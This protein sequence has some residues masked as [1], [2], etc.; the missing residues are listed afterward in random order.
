MSVSRDEPPKI[1]ITVEIRQVKIQDDIVQGA[2]A[3]TILRDEKKSVSVAAAHPDS[4]REA[5]GLQLREAHGGLH[6]QVRDRAG[7]RPARRALPR[8]P[9]PLQVQ[10]EVQDRR[11]VRGQALRQG[12]ADPGEKHQGAGRRALQRERQAHPGRDEE[13]RRRGD[14]APELAEE[15]V[16]D[17]AQRHQQRAAGPRE[18]RLLPPRRRR[19]E[20]SRAPQEE[21]KRRRLRRAGQARLHQPDTTG[22]Q[23]RQRARLDPHPQKTAGPRSVLSAHPAARSRT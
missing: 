8:D 14:H 10:Q 7:G 23:V 2:E 1:E 3:M 6:L 16:Q 5:S 15:R 19:E 11:L 9:L 17:Q 22:R 21:Q 12:R 4:V 13:H 20:D 18:G